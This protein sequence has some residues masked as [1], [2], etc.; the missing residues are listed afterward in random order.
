M[1]LQYDRESLFA[2][3]KVFLEDSL[4]EKEK[5]SGKYSNLRSVFFLLGVFFM[6]LAIWRN[7]LLWLIAIGT[8]FF[9]LFFA[10]V[11][12][13]ARVKRRIREQETLLEIH[14]EHEARVAHDFSSLEDDGGDFFDRNHDFSGDLDIFGRRSLYH[15][16]SIA[17]TWHG[18]NRLALTLMGSASSIEKN[19]IERRQKAIWELSEK[20]YWVEDL[21]CIGR[22]AGQKGK[23]PSVLLSYAKGDLTVP[24]MRKKKLILFFCLTIA[25]W[26]SVL[27]SL[28]TSFMPPYIPFALFGIQFITSAIQYS[29]FKKPLSDMNEFY[30]ELSSYT[31][32]FESVE[33]GDFSSLVLQ[34]IRDIFS[35]DSNG[36]SASERNRRLK[37]LSFFI[38]LRSQP[39]FYLLLN[40][41][42]LYDAYCI[43]FLEKWQ[44]ENGQKLEAYL[45]GIGELEALASLSMIRHVYPASQMPQIEDSPEKKI[46]FTAKDI[47]HPLIPEGRLVRNSFSLNGGTALVTGSNMSGKTTFLRTVGINAVLAYAGTFCCAENLCLSVMHIGT[48]MRIADDLGEGMS[49]FYAE[50]VRVGKIVQ[51]A[52]SG[53]PMLFLIDEIFRGTNSKDRTD[54]AVLVLQKLAQPWIMGIMSTHDYALCELEEEDGVVLHHFHFSESYDQEGIHFSYKLQPGISISSNA[55]YLMALMGI[56]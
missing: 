7:G 34:D 46:Y 52:Q 54:G 55:R 1:A 41:L 53:T 8:V 30:Q 32:L 31:H 20:F 15:L 33:K 37:L 35:G 3:R 27:L 10:A 45:K 21:Q 14:C 43:Y 26:V 25:F 24:V 9:F 39:L 17:Q 51:Y 18:R 16:I 36:G 5:M 2:S 42:F 4:A 28:T 40:T 11:V 49:T 22:L 13:H 47:G 48:S 50:L 29:S 56:K 23:D 12:F 38:H 6:G 44:R 19:T